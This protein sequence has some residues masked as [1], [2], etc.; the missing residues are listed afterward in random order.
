MCIGFDLDCSVS[1]TWKEASC[2]GN[3]VGE[4]S[5][6]DLYSKV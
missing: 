3:A 5:L 6:V 2:V 1:R 4:R